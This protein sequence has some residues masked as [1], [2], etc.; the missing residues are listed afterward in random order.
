[1]VR[2]ELEALIDDPTAFLR[3]EDPAVRRLAVS[4]CAARVDDARVVGALTATLDTD[5]DPRV[6][7][8]A[9]EVLAL[10][11]REVRDSL[12][13]HAGTDDPVVREAVAT[14]LGEIGSV[15][16]V[17]WLME[18][19]ASN[20]DR[21]VQEAAVA[22]LGA[23]GDERAVNLLLGLARS[24]QPQIRRRSVVALTAFDG[25]EVT[26]T[27]EA[28]TRDRNPMVREVAEM[29]IGRTIDGT[30]LP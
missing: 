11:G 22:A 30:D 3:D 13:R 9:A 8:E 10:A 28:A 20:D 1:M 27:I 14:G 26:A 5:D 17:P 7:A 24:G 4:S 15:D 23:I 2:M 29:L 21:L 18:A 6:R 19:A 12:L 16:A 25:D